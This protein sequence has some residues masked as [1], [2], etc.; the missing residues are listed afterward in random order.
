MP[1]KFSEALTMVVILKTEKKKKSERFTF[2]FGRVHF[3]EGDNN[4]QGPCSS[5]IEIEIKTLSPF[6]FSDTTELIKLL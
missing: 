3:S 4:L 2:A 6:L 5:Q 1:L